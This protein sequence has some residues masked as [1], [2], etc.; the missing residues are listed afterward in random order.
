VKV[1][2]HL[3]NATKPLVNV[4]IFPPRRGGKVE[5]IY[6]AVSSLLPYEPPFIDITSG[7]GPGGQQ[8]LCA[9]LPHAVLR[10][11]G[12]QDGDGIWCRVGSHAAPEGAQV[13]LSEMPH[14]GS[15]DRRTLP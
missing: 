2:E 7:S 8:G 10:Y 3:A 14:Q 15:P 9:T 13:G 6:E 4:E 11:P 5:R 1:I 12:R